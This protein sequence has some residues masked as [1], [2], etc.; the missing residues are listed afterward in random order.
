MGPPG[1]GGLGGSPQPHAAPVNLLAGG[2]GAFRPFSGSFLPLITTR[3]LTGMG[4]TGGSPLPALARGKCLPWAASPLG[5][6][7][8]CALVLVWSGGPLPAQGP[9]RCPGPPG[10]SSWPGIPWL[11]PPCPTEWGGGAAPI[12]APEGS[13]GALVHCAPQ[14]PLPPPAADRALGTF[15]LGARVPSRP[16]CPPAA[17]GER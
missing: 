11:W 3:R 1:S 16:Q 8:P 12:P 9:T 15:L 7:S 4:D 10:G 6:P 2:W 5:G 17:L 13:Q 14:C